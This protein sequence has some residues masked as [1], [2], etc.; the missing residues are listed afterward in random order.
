M[1]NDKLHNLL[2]DPHIQ[3]F[4]AATPRLKELIA[5]NEHPVIKQLRSDAKAELLADNVLVLDK[6][7]VL[8]FL[9]GKLDENGSFLFKM[10]DIRVVGVPSIL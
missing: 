3:F 7:D 5:S 8:N 10:G 6:A 2:N 9:T 1:M 4:L